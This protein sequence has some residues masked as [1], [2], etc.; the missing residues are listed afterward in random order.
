MKR[1]LPLVVLLALGACSE[2]PPPAPANVLLVIVDT[3]RADHMSLHG[4]ERETTPFLAELGQRE[5]T[6]VFQ[7]AKSPAPWTKPSVTSIM[8]GLF[9]TG[10]AADTHVD[11]MHSDFETLGEAFADLGFDTG[12]VQSN[13]LVASF[14]GYDQGFRFW[15]EK[16]LARHDE[17]VG[18]GINAETRRFLEEPR[19][20]PFF[21]YVH[22]YEPHFQYMQSGERWYPDYPGPL[23][24][25]E[26]MDQLFGAL[27]QLRD[28][29]IRFLE[30]RYDADILYQDELLRELFADLERS[31]YADDTLVVITSD[32]GEEFLEHGEI[33]HQ[34]KLFEELLHVPLIVV[35]P[36]G[37]ASPL[38][39]L[40]PADLARNVSTVDIGATLFDL[41]DKPTRFPGH[42]LLDS[43]DDEVVAQVVMLTFQQ[44]DQYPLMDA[45]TA[46]DWKL[47]RRNE[48]DGTR[49]YA[50]YNLEADP[51][52][53]DD[54][55]AAEPERVA[56]LEARL[57]A[58]V[59]ERA[60]WIPPG[61]RIDEDVEYTAE[62]I[63]SMK[64]LGYL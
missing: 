2:P 22:H 31:G 10:H 42:S 57:D 28:E 34:Y 4:Y 13:K 48:L 6:F 58:L 15:S 54:R 29:E 16:H 3:L 49:S 30:S 25:N 52:E 40:T 12:G 23:T 32:H 56:E 43:T 62:Q 8:T 39:A 18:E 63:E 44:E 27:D 5:G 35:D 46:G 36:R 21:L 50:L 20:Q 7:N 9:P 51:A 37:A 19:E 60:R 24:G 53:L 1:C 45:V 64:H 38:A 55:A 59:A 61:E 47:V 14:Q 17:M 33:S 41:V 11:R 26:S